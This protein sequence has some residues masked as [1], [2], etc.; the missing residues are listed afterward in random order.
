MINVLALVAG[1][2]VLLVLAWGYGRLLVRLSKRQE[3]PDS[4]DKRRGYSLSDVRG[5][6]TALG[7]EGRAAEERFLRWDLSYP[8]A[9]GGALGAGVLITWSRLTTLHVVPPVALVAPIVIASVADWVEGLVHLRQLRRYKSGGAAAVEEGPIRL[10]S[11]ATLT[12][13]A[14][15]LLSILILGVLVLL[16]PFF[17]VQSKE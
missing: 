16:L 17:A 10:A 3:R 1:I 7:K 15:L 5:Y 4:L 14:F 8:F 12:K 6:W 9:Y 2:V 11:I 13:L